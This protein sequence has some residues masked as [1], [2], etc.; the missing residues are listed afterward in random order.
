M[1]KRVARWGCVEPLQKGDDLCE[2]CVGG[3]RLKVHFLFTHRARHHLHGACGIVAPRTH[4]DANPTAVAG[5]EQ[6][7]MPAKQALGCERLGMLLGCVQHHVHHAVY[8][9]V[10]GRQRTDVHPQ[11]TG[12]RR[13]HGVQ[14]QRLALDGAG[15]DDFLGEGLQRGLVSLRQPK[16][17]HAPRQMPLRAVHLCQ[18]RGQGSRVKPPLRPVGALPDVG[19]AGLGLVRV[20]AAIMHPIR[21]IKCGE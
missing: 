5:G 17:S 14:V 10:G 8:V 7:C 16:L 21:R 12:N 2:E 19:A 1:D 13:A 15:G 3:W 6:R 4:L 9:A 11:P 20:H 18:R